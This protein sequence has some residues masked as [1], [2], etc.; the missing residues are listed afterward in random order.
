MQYDPWKLI[1][2]ETQSPPSYV[3]GPASTAQKTGDAG[4]SLPPLSGAPAQQQQNGGFDINAARQH[5]RN[6]G[7]DDSSPEMKALLSFAEITQPPKPQEMSWGV[8]IPQALLAAGQAGF[9]RIGGADHNSAVSQAL[10]SSGIDSLAAANQ[11]FADAQNKWRGDVGEMLFKTSMAEAERAR[12][13]RLIGSILGTGGGSGPA[14]SIHKDGAHGVSTSSPRSSAQAT[15]PIP[16]Q[17]GIGQDGGPSAP[18]PA[19]TAGPAPA[20]APQ[21]STATGDD[22]LVPKHTVSESDLEPLPHTPQQIAAA[23][24]VL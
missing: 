3:T 4:F 20:T 12:K 16:H 15:P 1:P 18:A 10:G 6:L 7:L 11:K 13:E 2:D 19:S 14:G 9:A 8:A 23:S 21:L 24:L 17:S 5:M 22:N